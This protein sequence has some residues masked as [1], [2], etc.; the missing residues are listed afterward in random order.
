MNS[1]ILFWIGF[2]VFVLLMLTLD[3]G[4]FHKK[5]HDV[6]IKEAV[7]WSAVW[8]FLAMVF[9]VIVYFNFG[10]QKAFE[11]L[12]GY[13]IEKSLSVDNIFVFV[14]VFGYFQIPNKYQHKVLFW[15]IIGAL[16]MRIIF[17]VAGVSLI[18]QFHWTI[19]IFGAFLVFTGIKMITQKDKK[20]EPEK[21]PVVRLAR[22]FFSV[23]DNLHGDKF[24]VRQDGKKYVTPL[25]LVLI[26]IEVT[27]L[28][29]A[30]DSIPAILAITQDRFIVYTSNVF[31]ILG[32]RS[33]YFA[34]AHIVHRFI[35]LSYGLAVILMFVGTK[36]ML[37]DFFKIP[38]YVSLIII[39]FI[40]SVSIILS[41]L[42]TKSAD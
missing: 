3:L 11:F 2:N 36:M 18:Q 13:L 25:F 28:I 20:M 30:V 33:L 29:F 22:K 24:F 4:V 41:L 19:Y 17:I 31:A 15:G 14:L 8:I 39:A 23:T 34:L 7:I 26:L 32:L 35:Y 21:N 27:D 6:S 10:S 42:K 37:V 38:V 1:E 5:A 16:V 40:L 12:T 9:N